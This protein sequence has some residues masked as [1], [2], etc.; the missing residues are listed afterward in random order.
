MIFTSSIPSGGIF[1]NE[2]LSLAVIAG[3]RRII[4]VEGVE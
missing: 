4:L 1:Y 3:Y 2:R